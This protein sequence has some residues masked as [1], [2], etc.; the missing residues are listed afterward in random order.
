MAESAAT[1]TAPEPSGRHRAAGAAERRRRSSRRLRLVSTVGLGVGLLLIAIP[2]GTDLLRTVGLDGGTGPQAGVPTA[3]TDPPASPPIATPQPGPAADGT[4]PSGTP[5]PSPTAP[6]P[7]PTPRATTRPTP[8]TGSPSPQP[9]LQGA[10]VPAPS[11]TTGTP[12]ATDPAPPAPPA[13]PP[14]PQPVLLGPDGRSDLVRM[15]ESYCDEHVGGLSWA[16]TRG[17]GWECRRLLLSSRAVD[18]DRAC[19]DT[20]GDGAFAENPQG[21][22]PFGWRCFRR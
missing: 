3:V 19:R 11:A 13:A 4:A 21:R 16:E 15:M 5:D 12:P 22:D 7:S 6:D 14:P 18:L 1:R 20:F 2:F 10:A 9:P 8:P 17:D